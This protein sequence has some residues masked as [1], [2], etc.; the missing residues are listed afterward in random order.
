MPRESKTDF[1]ILGVLSLMP[2][3]GYDIK[4]FISVSIG[5]FWRESYGQ[6]YP[7]LRRLRAAGRVSRSIE[8]RD[9]RPDRH[10]Y[11]ITE[12]GRQALETWLEAETDPEHLRNEL[13]LKLFCG[14]LVPPAVHRQQVEALLE[15]Q[16]DRL[17]QFDT[18]EETTLK[19]WQGTPNHPYFLSTLR[20]GMHVTRARVEWCRETLQR[21]DRIEHTG[22]TVGPNE[23]TEMKP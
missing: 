22:P 7:T 20:F 17:E 18:V 21:L 19:E 23:D 1:A 5:F 9:G 10:L 2:M 8:R 4:R 16:L 3:S 6:I 13:L 11:S 14:P 15:H 12:T